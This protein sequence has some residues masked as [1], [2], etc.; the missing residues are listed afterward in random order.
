VGLLQD[1][2]RAIIRPLLSRDVQ[3]VQQFR[4]VSKLLVGLLESKEFRKK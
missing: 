1:W 4:E 3:T 2:R